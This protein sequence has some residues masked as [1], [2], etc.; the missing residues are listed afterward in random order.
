MRSPAVSVIIPVYNRAGPVAQAVASLAAQTLTDHEIIVVDDGSTDG[1]A[2]AAERAGR[3]RV[4]VIRHNVNRG[5]PTA[6]NSG[7]AAARGRYIAWLDSDDIARPRRLERQLRF[8]EGRSELAMIGAGAGRVR[9][10]GRRKT[11]TRVPLFEHRAIAPALLF[12]SPF[13]QSTVMGRAAIFKQFPYRPE[14]PVCED[15]DMFIRLTAQHRAA[16]IREVLVDRRMH[17]DQIGR[18]E[19]A[20]VRDRKRVL[21]GQQLARLGLDF[22]SDD[23]D[24]HITLGAPKNMPQPPEMLAWSKEWLASLQRA[25]AAVRLYDPD[26]LALAS[27]VTWATLCRASMRGRRPMHAML[28]LVA[29]SLMFGFFGSSGLNWLSGALPTLLLG[30]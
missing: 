21:L 24:R 26:G 9:S 2:E 23:L 27:A 19:S 10:D 30:S 18:S 7:L 11:G 25:N 5:I 1:S 14:F 13:Q 8:L 28:E 6:R 12:R 20:L 15:L 17:P 22:S 4:R 3:G 16:N 29:S